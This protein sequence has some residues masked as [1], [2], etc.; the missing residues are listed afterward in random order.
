MKYSCRGFKLNSF[1]SMQVFKIIIVIVLRYSEFI[2]NEVVSFSLKI[3]DAC[4]TTYV[5][6]FLVVIFVAYPRNCFWRYEI[7][8]KAS[9]GCVNAGYSGIPIYFIDRKTFSKTKSTSL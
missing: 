8:A 6:L 3:I 4:Y 9:E 7:D 5:S 2:R 1:Y